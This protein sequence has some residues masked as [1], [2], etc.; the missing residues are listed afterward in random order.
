MTVRNPAYRRPGPLNL[1]EDQ[2]ARLART[3]LDYCERNAA[4]ERLDDVAVRA[5][6]PAL[7]DDATWAE[8]VR[9]LGL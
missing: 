3:V 8:L 5:L 4:L 7:A 2:W 1:T 6:H 9:R